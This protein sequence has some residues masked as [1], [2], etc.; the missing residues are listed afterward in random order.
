[1]AGRV[2]RDGQQYS[3]E[4]SLGVVAAQREWEAAVAVADPSVIELFCG[5]RQLAAYGDQ[6]GELIA[7]A[8][9]TVRAAFVA[10]AAATWGR[11]WASWPG[12]DT[13]RPVLAWLT[14]LSDYGCA[15]GLRC[16]R[17]TAPQR[18]VTS[19]IAAISSATR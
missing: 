12:T 3:P 16:E 18:S 8:S 11:R 10:A 6:A 4:Y 19:R 14:A 2:I 7:A 5:V 9:S 17:S 15:A 1:M 13:A